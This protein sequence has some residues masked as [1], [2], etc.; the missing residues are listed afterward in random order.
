MKQGKIGVEVTFE[1]EK[2]VVE[3][4]KQL[5]DQVEIP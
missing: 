2:K 3:R 5:G 4:E 1:M